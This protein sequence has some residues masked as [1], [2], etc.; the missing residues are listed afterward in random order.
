METVVSPDQLYKLFAGKKVFVTGHSGFKGTWLIAMLHKMGAEIKGYSLLPEEYA[1]DFFGLMESLPN[2]SHV[3]ADI[4]D[5]EKLRAE[6]LSFAPD[7]VF[8]LAAQAL[9]L[10]SYKEPEYTFDV[11]V[12][13]TVNLLHA[14]AGLQKTCGIVVVT[15]DKVYANSGSPVYFKES[16][17]LGGH[18]PYSASKACTELVIQSIRD[19]YF[20][21]T[22]FQHHCKGIAAARAGNVIG[23]GDWNS[24]RIVPD[25]ARS[26]SRNIPIV[27]RN[28]DAIRPWQHVLEPLYAYL[29]LA[30]SVAEDPVKFGR[31]FN[32]GPLPGDHLPVLELTKLAIASWGRG[33][34]SVNEELHKPHE[35][36][37]LQLDISLAKQEL[38]WTPRLNAT[39]AIH[40]T[41]DWYKQEP[42][43][44][45]D[46]TFNQIDQY[47]SL[48]N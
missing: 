32:F 20:P 31:A 34:Y 24:N 17:P 7:Y 39:E 40:W 38:G 35:A 22:A 36:N 5:K 15:T 19:S 28:P 27:L 42:C 16:D 41:I 30:V 44:K 13:G 46:F 23:G 25:I 3:F 12:N 21:P 9:V 18:D 29:Q 14:L 33:S 11:N 8:H 48:W 45:F 6:L 10:R 26:I 1:G 43:D 47:L 2:V 4:R 37:Y